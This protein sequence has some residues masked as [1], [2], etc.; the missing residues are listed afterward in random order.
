MP[1]FK[2]IYKRDKQGK[3]M[4]FIIFQSSVIQCGWGIWE[5]FNGES[6]YDIEWDKE[7]IISEKLEARCLSLFHYWKQK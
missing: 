2:T 5:L 3:E 1:V 7:E 4:I 6:T